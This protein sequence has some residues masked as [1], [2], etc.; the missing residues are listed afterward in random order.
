MERGRHD[1]QE[2][3]GVNEWPGGKRHAMSQTDHEKWNTLHYP[4]TRQLCAICDEPTGRCED[5]TL[6]VDNID[7]PLCE[8]CWEENRVKEFPPC[9]TK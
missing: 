5:D 2:G 7:G 3:E 4:G 1:G 6:S 9:P 8:K